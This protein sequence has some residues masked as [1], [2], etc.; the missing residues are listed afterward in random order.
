MKKRK[1][2]KCLIILM[3][4]IL[5]IS[6]CGFTSCDAVTSETKY[7][8]KLSKEADS[9]IGYPNITNFFEKAQLKA[10][11]ELRDD[12]KLICYWYTQ[13]LY[14]GKW[15]YQGECVGYGIPYSTQYTAPTKVNNDDT[16][17]NT[18]T[19]QA[20]PNDLYSTGSTT[21]TWILSADSQGNIKPRQVEGDIYVTQ[22]KV[23]ASMCEDWSIPKGY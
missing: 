18:T 13:N 8:E 2:I 6:L 3:A 10:I 19:E 5:L 16:G 21:A 20:D 9:S 22:D 4:T 7:T 15:I 23:N 1:N 14:T 11:Y 17:G 12:P